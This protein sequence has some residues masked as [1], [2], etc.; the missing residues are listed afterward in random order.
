M[1]VKGKYIQLAYPV[2][3]LKKLAYGKGKELAENYDKIMQVQY[4]SRVLQNI[5]VFL[6]NVFWPVLTLTILCFVM[7]TV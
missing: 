5:I 3:Q 4:D 7:V 6:R 2:E 1:D